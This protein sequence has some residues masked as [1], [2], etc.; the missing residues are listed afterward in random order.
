MAGFVGIPLDIT[1]RYFFHKHVGI[2]FGLQDTILFN[3]GSGSTTRATIYVNDADGNSAGSCRAHG[4]SS[5]AK[6]G[7]K[8]TLKFGLTTRW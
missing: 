1:G 8:F 7:N 4:E 6:V 5:K 3:L 2:L